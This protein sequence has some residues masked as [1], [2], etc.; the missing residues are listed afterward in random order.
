MEGSQTFPITRASPYLCWPGCTQKSIPF[1]AMIWGSVWD[2]LVCLC[3]LWTWKSSSVYS[4]FITVCSW[5]RKS[6]LL[7]KHEV[8]TD[9]NYIWWI[10]QISLKFQI[11]PAHNNPLKSSLF[12]IKNYCYAVRRGQSVQGFIYNLVSNGLRN[13]ATGVPSTNH[14]VLLC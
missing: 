3:T 12:L 4:F 13:L 8:Q 2:I 14:V 6:L 9:Q 1:S 11:L 7:N 10:S 5:S